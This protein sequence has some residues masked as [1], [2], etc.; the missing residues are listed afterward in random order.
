MVINGV[1]FSGIYGAGVYR[2]AVTMSPGRILKLYVNGVCQPLPE[3][4]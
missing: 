3:D 2:V 1:D 4:D